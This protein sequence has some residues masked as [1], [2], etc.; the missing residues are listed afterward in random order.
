MRLRNQPDVRVYMVRRCLAIPNHRTSLPAQVMKASLTTP[1]SM[2][3]WENQ[4]GAMMR[5]AQEIMSQSKYH[6]VTQAH[7]PLMIFSL[8][9]EYVD[10]VL[11]VCTCCTYIRDAFHS[12]LWAVMPWLSCLRP[13]IPSPNNP[14]LANT[15]IKA[16]WAFL[17][18]LV[19]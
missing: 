16:S 6:L 14:Y 9:E 10:G 12:A 8:P 11:Y 7:H 18:T 1:V 17:G 3:M 13:L 15:T 4:N 2:H 5:G 19:N